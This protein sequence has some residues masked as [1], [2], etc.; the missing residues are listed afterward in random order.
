VRNSKV[1]FD[2]FLQTDPT[3][4]KVCAEIRFKPRKPRYLC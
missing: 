3:F 2:S 1:F 4:I